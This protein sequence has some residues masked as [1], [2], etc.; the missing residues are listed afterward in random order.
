MGGAEQGPA[1][2]P[3]S[4]PPGRRPRPSPPSASALRAKPRR[5]PR[6]SRLMRPRHPRGRDRPLPF[7]NPR[8]RPAPRPRN[9]SRAPNRQPSPSRAWVA[10]WRP[11]AL[12]I[13]APRARAGLGGMDRVSGESRHAS[14]EHPTLDSATGIP[15]APRGAPGGP[16]ALIADSG[17]G[18]AALLPPGDPLA[19]RPRPPRL[20]CPERAKSPRLPL[21]VKITQ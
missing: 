7:P 15:L 9:Q 21:H 8:D 20:A 14:P 11:K 1:R 19:P 10:G 4:R 12:P 5:G 16:P 3:A 6:S 17:F 2:P 13:V 18:P